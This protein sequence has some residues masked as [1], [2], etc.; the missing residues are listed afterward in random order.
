M[1]AGDP[2]W[3]IRL[4]NRSYISSRDGNIEL[5]DGSAVAH[6]LTPAERQYIEWADETAKRWGSPVFEPRKGR[7]R[8]CIYYVRIDGNFSLLDFGVCSFTGGPFD[9]RV[10]NVNSGCP[11]FAES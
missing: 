10:I 5:T 11:E 9:G 2:E 3:T 1:V 4:N 8:D 7:C 6:E